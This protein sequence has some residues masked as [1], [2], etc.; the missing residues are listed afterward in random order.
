MST[1]TLLLSLLLLSSL[2]TSSFA[3][4][5]KFIPPKLPPPDPFCPRDVLKLGTCADLLGNVASV[6]AGEPL[7][8]KCCAL[9]QGLADAEA[10]LCLC[11]AVKES[12]LGVLTAEWSVAV[13]SVASSCKKEIPDGFKCV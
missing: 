8:A 3:F 1:K 13:S 7:G 2:H 6:V 4:K 10:A 11:T 5:P 9:L 12:V